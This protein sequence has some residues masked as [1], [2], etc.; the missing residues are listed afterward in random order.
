[1]ITADRVTYQRLAW[2]TPL[3]LTLLAL[4]LAVLVWLLATPSQNVEA[5]VPLEH[6]VIVT[7][8]AL[9]AAA[10][11]LL[12]ARGALQ[13]VQ[14]QMLF[15]ALGFMTMGGLFWVHALATPGMIL[16]GY[17][18][19]GTVTG[20]S[21]FLS[22]F[23]PSLFFAARY[24]P[25]GRALGRREPAEVRGWLTLI[26]GAIVLTLVVFAVLGIHEHQFLER[27]P[28]SSPPAAYGLV[29]VTVGLLLFAAWREGRS[30]QQTG[31]P[32]RGALAIAYV[33]LA[34]ASI[35]MA[36]GPIWTLAWWEYHVLMLS[37]VILALG[38]LFVELERRRGLEQFLPAPLVERV[39]AGDAPSLRGERR[40]VTILFA[41]MRGST[42]LAERLPAEDIVELL[43]T[44]LGGLT[45]CIFD[46]GGVLDKFT[47][48]GLMATFGLHHEQGNGA[49]AA[50]R[51]A[52]AI[53]AAIAA[54]SAERARD[55]DST[56]K[57][58]VGIN[59]GD[60][61]LGLVGIPQRAD[62]MAIGDTVN[63]A[64]RLESLCKQ[65]AVDNVLSAATVAGLAGAGLSVRP[66]GTVTVAGK[67]QPI[68][69]YTLT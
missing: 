19:F 58:G 12:L 46:H 38:A 24:L 10:V 6:F 1:M 44:Y 37:A 7:N 53:R 32:M 4:P 45:R 59:T 33:L 61:T 5:R 30:Y 56:A 16:P 14:Y 2:R 60:V 26:T 8:V 13:L 22:L 35:A 20:L 41:D 39:L 62:Y 27:L 52:L 69:T 28:F 49:V 48:D 65:F 68:E 51:S 36:L 50:A 66:L 43:N 25:L 23:V 3:I 63:T 57:F 64:A 18:Y 29:A 31:L 40:E 55:G 17:T 21:A 11:A 15:P 47:G 9:V 34:E 42:S 67:S 54:I